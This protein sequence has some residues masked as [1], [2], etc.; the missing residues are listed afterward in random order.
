L[1]ALLEGVANRLEKENKQRLV[2]AWNIAALTRIK[3]MPSLKRLL[4]QIGPNKKPS[5]KLQSQSWQRQLK[6]AEQWH[7]L[8]SKPQRK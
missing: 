2:L 8:L 3:R 5:P 6:I 1:A 4:E 7:R